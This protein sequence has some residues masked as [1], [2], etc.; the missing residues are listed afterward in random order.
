MGDLLILSADQANI[1]SPG[2]EILAEFW[3]HTNELCVL[4]LLKSLSLEAVED[5]DTMILDNGIGVASDCESTRDIL[6]L[7]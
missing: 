3:L 4:N 1:A 5:Q 7:S 2:I 6:M